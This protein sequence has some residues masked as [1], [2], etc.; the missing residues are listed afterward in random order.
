MFHIC[1]VDIDQSRYTL[2][3]VAALAVCCCL[4]ACHDSQ[5]DDF[6]T[7]EATGERVPI[8]LNISNPQ[9]VVSVVQNAPK[10]RRNAPGVGTLG[11]WD[12]DSMM[13]KDANFHVFA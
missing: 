1:N 13:W 10:G 3:A 5:A 6:L 4:G 7:P 8:A 2:R 12:P 11:A 9:F